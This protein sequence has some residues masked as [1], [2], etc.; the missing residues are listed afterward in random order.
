MPDP[1]RATPEE[2]RVIKQIV[3]DAVTSREFPAIDVGQVLVSI[4]AAM[5]KGSDATESEFLQYARQA[6]S[7]QRSVGSKEPSS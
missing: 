7:A 6:W 4:G 3:I 1:K 5:M 2:R